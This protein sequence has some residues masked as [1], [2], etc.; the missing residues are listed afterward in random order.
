MAPAGRRIHE[1]L[2][3]NSMGAGDAD[4]GALVVAPLAGVVTF[5][6]RWD[7]ASAGFGTHL[8]VFLDDPRAAAPCSLHVAHLD[9][10]LVRAGQRVVAGQ[11]LGTCGKT[12]QPTPMSTPR[13]GTPPPPGGWGF[14]QAGY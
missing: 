9:D 11:V 12:G 8:A 7:A 2:D 5:V 4:L 6:G 3:L 13:S 14:W 1:G 10:L